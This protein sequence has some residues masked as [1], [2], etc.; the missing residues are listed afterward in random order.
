MRQGH[1]SKRE[2]DKSKRWILAQTER[3]GECLCANNPR[4][5]IVADFGLVVVEEGIRGR[6]S[7]P[8]CL[9][10]VFELAR[11]LH[12]RAGRAESADQG[13]RRSCR[14][15]RSADESG[16][17]RRTAARLDRYRPAAERVHR[18]RTTDRRA[19]ATRWL[20]NFRLSVSD[21][22]QPL[23]FRCWE[24]RRTLTGGA[25]VSKPAAVGGKDHARAQACCC[26]QAGSFVAR[27]QLMVPVS[28][29]V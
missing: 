6:T 17:G 16:S 12:E 2:R 9:L 10:L 18:D 11:L 28:E 25:Q 24:I 13:L 4:L 26:R 22:L 3:S 21:F 20:R 23:G 7:L 27:T 29:S 5:F 8:Q 14:G 19:A 15:C 1:M